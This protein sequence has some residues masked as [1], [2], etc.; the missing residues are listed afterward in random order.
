[1]RYGQG[2][3]K[4]CVKDGERIQNSKSRNNEYIG[5]KYEKRH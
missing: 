5:K 3:E 2:G 1:M 4:R